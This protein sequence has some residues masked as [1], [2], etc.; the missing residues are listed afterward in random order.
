MKRTPTEATP[1]ANDDIFGR[2][3]YICPS[4]RVL[5]GISSVMHS[6]RSML[7]T[8]RHM[9]T[10]S[11]YGIVVSALKTAAIMGRLALMRPFSPVRIVHI[12]GG[13]GKSWMRKSLILSWAKLLGY[14][15]VMHVHGGGFKKYIDRT[16]SR[17]IR[18]LLGRCDR[19][20]T[21][22][23]GWQDYFTRELGLDNVTVINN[24]VTR[25]P[26]QTTAS[27]LAAPMRGTPGKPMRFVFLGRIC[28]LKGV[29]DLAE[30]IGRNAARWRGRAQFTIGGTGEDQKLADTLDRLG[31]ADM[32]Q[33]P[34]WVDG[35]DKQRLIDAADVMMLP[36]YIEC[37]P[38]C[39]LEAMASAMPSIATE[40][41]GIPEIITTGV[42]G[43]LI[44]PV[45][46]TALTAAIDHYLDHPG[47]VVSHGREGL[48]RVPAFYPQ[49]V[50]A[51]LSQLYHGLLD[52]RKD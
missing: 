41:G 17:R 9:A 50:K 49:A 22:T 35:K 5:G 23:H 38:V 14:K 32:V 4:M 45:D 48:A 10:N 51:Q 39:L 16:G 52:A 31:I 24:V 44:P 13:S 12:H 19:V 34:G 28:Q 6:Y 2:V 40:V 21:L 26:A 33:T 29:Y 47:D 30:V 11:R 37:L 27:R 43:I 15:V 20:V 7:P 3:V 18:R 8:F 46:H 1:R 42:N 25:Q 36:S